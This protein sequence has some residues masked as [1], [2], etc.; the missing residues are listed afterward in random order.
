MCLWCK[1]LLGTDQRRKI[2]PKMIRLEYTHSMVKAEERGTYCFIC[3]GWKP[4]LLSCPSFSESTHASVIS[5]TSQDSLPPGQI[6][7]R[8]DCTH[9]DSKVYSWRGS[10]WYQR[11]NTLTHGS[12]PRNGDSLEMESKSIP[13]NVF[14]CP[15]LEYKGREKIQKY[16]PIKYKTKAKQLTGSC[17]CYINSKIW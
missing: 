14:Q 2:W 7:E 13:N 5:E 8:P 3:G 11:L 17:F 16:F 10:K 15:S 4:S 9:K 6:W 12:H 1:N